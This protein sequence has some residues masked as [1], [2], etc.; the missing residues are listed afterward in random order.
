MEEI[1][2]RSGGIKLREDNILFMLST[3]LKDICNQHGIFIMSATQ[4]NGDYQESKTPDQN[5]LRGAKAIADKIDYGSILLNV[6][7]DDL[8]ALDTILSSNLFERPTIKM[9]VYKNRRGRYKGV[10]L[11][12]KADLGCCRIKPMFC[13]TYDYEM[14]NIDDMRITLQEESAFEIDD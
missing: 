5:L 3:R 11:W 6:K 8:V 7:D 12:C 4:L 9:S 1:T 13:T 10:I 14:V 2:R